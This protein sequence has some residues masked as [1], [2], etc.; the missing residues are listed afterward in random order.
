MNPLVIYCSA[1]HW[2]I[3]T[4]YPHPAPI[5]VKKRGE[6]KWGSCKAT[7]VMDLLLSICPE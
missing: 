1:R 2:L 6:R 3:P 5:F 4:P 7:V